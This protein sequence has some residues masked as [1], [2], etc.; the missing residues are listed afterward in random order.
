MREYYLLHIIG[1]KEPRDLGYEQGM[2]LAMILISPNQPKFVLIDDSVI[3]VSSISGLEKINESFEY[4]S[5]LNHLKKK[6]PELTESEKETLEKYTA[7]KNQLLGQ[8]EI[9]QLN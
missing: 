9:P 5:Y 2:K 1:Q 7:M 8:K 4:P 6:V 3:A